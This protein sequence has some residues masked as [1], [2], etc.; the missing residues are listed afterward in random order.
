M[1]KCKAIF[2]R[3]SPANLDELNTEIEGL[4]H[5]FLTAK[6]IYKNTISYYTDECINVPIE[7]LN[8]LTG[9]DKCGLCFVQPSND[10]NKETVYV[11]IQEERYKDLVDQGHVL[12]N[13]V[14]R[15]SVST[16]LINTSH[17]D[18][19]KL[20]ETH[21]DRITKLELR[22]SEQKN[23]YNKIH[24]LYS[25]SI[26]QIVELKRKLKENNTAL[27]S[28]E[29]NKK[30]FKTT[31]NIKQCIMDFQ[32]LD[33]YIKETI[34]E[35]TGMRRNIYNKCGINEFVKLNNIEDI[36][37]PFELTAKQF[38]TIFIKAKS[39]RISVAHPISEMKNRNISRLLKELAVF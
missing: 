19:T 27:N 37:K 26:N 35:T 13:I 22:L 33:D 1:E 34:Y 8:E 29:Q 20:K 25:G 38:K 32:L 28:L 7:K 16:I 14:N 9:N 11:I 12:K 5:D 6:D 17:K 31:E 10:T 4:K 24:M 23:K 15:D 39:K 2:K 3:F 18:N 30:H 36:L 21:S